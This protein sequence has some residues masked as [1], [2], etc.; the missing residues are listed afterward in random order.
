M[1]EEISLVNLLINNKKQDHVMGIL[2][3]V[4][5]NN[6]G[7]LINEL[8]LIIKRHYCVDSVIS[9]G[10][11]PEWV[12][13]RLYPEFKVKFKTTGDK[14]FKSELFISCIA[15]YSGSSHR[16]SSFERIG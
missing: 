16:E 5:L 3:D 14:P 2:K 1:R 15:I 6:I 12:S 7:S 8:Q 10:D 9:P 13:S 11:I 4:D